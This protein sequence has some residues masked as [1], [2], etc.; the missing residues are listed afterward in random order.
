MYLPQK[1][2]ANAV[3]VTYVDPDRDYTNQVAA[4]YSDDYVDSTT[5]PKKTSIKI[6]AAIPRAQAVRQAAFYLNSNKYLVRVIEFEAAADSFTAQL[7]DLVYFQHFIPQYD[8]RLG[9]RVV[10]AGNDDGSGNPYVQ[11]D[12][13]ITLEAGTNYG[14]LVRLNDD[15]LVEKA[16]QVQASTITTDTLL[17]QSD[18]SEIPQ[19]YDLYAF[20]PADTYKKPY[21]ITNITRA[22]DLTRRITLMEYVAEIYNDTN[23]IIETPTWDSPIVQEA[24]QVSTEEFLTVSKSGDYQSNINVSWNA[25]TA[26]IK[27]N[28]DVWLIDESLSS[29]W[30]DATFEDETFAETLEQPGLWHAGRSADMSFKIGPDRLSLNNEYT[31][32]VSPAGEAPTDTGENSSRIKILGKLA[33]PNDVTVFYATWNSIKRTVNFVW[34]EVNNV[35][36]SH[37]EIRQGLTWEDGTVV[38]KAAKSGSASIAIPEGTSEIRKYFI[39]AVDTSGIYSENA[40]EVNVA[41]HTAD[42]PLLVPTGLSLLSE[43]TIVNDGT[44]R[45]ILI[46]NWDNNAEVN[47]NFHHYTLLLED[48]DSGYKSEYLTKE[49]QYQW[50]LS[51]NKQYGVSVQAVDVS[52]NETS[53]SSQVTITTAKDDNAPSVPAWQATSLVPGFK[54]IGLRW[55]KNSEPDLSHYVVERSTTGDFTG[56]EIDLGNKDGN[57]TTDTDLAVSTEY[58]Y[59][60]KAVDTSGNASGWST[61]KSATTLQVGQADI[62]YNSIIAEHIDVTNLAAINA[63]LGV[64][65]AGKLQSFDG[66]FVIDLDN[67]LIEIQV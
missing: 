40:P 23:Y 49:H 15:S 18:W 7:G 37:Y 39:K 48:I 32:I 53:Y 12:Q 1:D 4:V 61:I 25:T 55:I 9:G 33:P 51:P 58:F 43:S 41:I 46:A 10:D 34:T 59:R 29:Y 6:N 38:V 65:T 57:F 20:G 8:E 28:W 45:S 24:T 66:N 36:A 31:V 14:I 47:D 63:N 62:A 16:L 42:C 54:T 52:G 13:E 30:E 56:E 21:R 44:D 26:H 67:K 22:Q 60:I 35:D 3:E 19:Q 17:L 11:L 64:I 2:R 5:T 27:W 50:Q